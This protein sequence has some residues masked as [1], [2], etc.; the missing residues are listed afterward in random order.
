MPLPQRRSNESKGEFVTR[1][2]TAPI[3]EEEYPRNKQRMA[4]CLNL[5]DRGNNT[6]FG[7]RGG[8]RKTP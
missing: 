1:C 8:K 6:D 7:I 2:Y 5:A 3:M 4:I